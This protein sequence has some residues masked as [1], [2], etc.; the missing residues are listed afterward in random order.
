MPSC[1]RPPG[2]IVRMSA[3]FARRRSRG[4]STV[5][6]D[7][8]GSSTNHNRIPT[9]PPHP[10]APA[11]ESSGGALVHAGVME[12]VSGTVFRRNSAGNEGPALLSL[13]IVQTISDVTFEDNVFYCDTG[14]YSRE[15]VISPVS[16]CTL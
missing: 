8:T 15:A 12:E 1:H 11:A 10:H 4:G 14:T 6:A 3:L 7:R 9:P 16:C 2:R 13:G 5:V